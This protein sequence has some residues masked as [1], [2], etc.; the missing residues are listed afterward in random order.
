LREDLWQRADLDLRWA[1]GLVRPQA[2]SPREAS[3]ISFAQPAWGALFDAHDA[4]AVGHGIEYRHPLIDLRLIRFA[5]GLPAFPWCVDKEL[6]RRCLDDLPAPLR[7]R[8]KT[9]LA[10]DPMVARVAR[11]ELAPL[12]TRR[13]SRELERFVDPLALE[14]TL[15]HSA[16]DV[17][18]GIDPWPLLR[19]VALDAWL[20]VRGEAP[21]VDVK[22]AAP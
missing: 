8:P 20:E 21:V 12:A 11:G 18:R 22:L 1:R 2:T 16:A 4:A 19:A 7:R 14:H 3:T 15:A 17:R 5:L 10:A 9:V 13:P 6:L